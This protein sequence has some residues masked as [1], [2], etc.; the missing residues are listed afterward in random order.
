M[1]TNQSTTQDP[2]LRAA[3]DEVAE[4]INKAR[5]V[6]DDGVARGLPYRPLAESGS[7]DRAYCTKLARAAL[8]ATPAHAPGKAGD[9]EGLDAAEMQ[10]DA[11]AEAILTRRGFGYYTDP[12]EGGQD[13]YDISCEAREEAIAALKAAKQFIANGVEFGFIRMPDSDTPDTAHATPR[14]IEKALAALAPS[15]TGN[16][17]PRGEEHDALWVPSS[18]DGWVQKAARHHARGENMGINNEDLGAFMSALAAAPPPPVSTEPDSRA[19]DDAGDLDKAHERL[20]EILGDFVGEVNNGFIADQI[21]AEFAS[22]GSPQPDSPAPAPSGAER[23]ALVAI[24][25][26]RKLCFA[27]CGDGICTCQDRP[28]LPAELEAPGQNAAIS[29]APTSSEAAAPVVEAQISKAAHRVFARLCEFDDRTSP[30]EYPDMVLVTADE[31]SWL[32]TEELAIPTP[33][34]H[35]VPAGQTTGEV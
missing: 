19:H 10:I 8:S 20:V 15:P 35:P 2:G 34:P 22:S 18:R 6:D 7:I 32:M 3:L 1:T 31:L 9:R 4:A 14:L 30:E 25:T 24:P 28:L 21:I 11:A 27:Y 16:E 13:A 33:A 29:S 23:E 17:A 26:D 12:M 5:Y